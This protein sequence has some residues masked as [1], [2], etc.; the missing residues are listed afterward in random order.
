MAYDLGT[1]VNAQNEAGSDAN[2]NPGVAIFNVPGTSA[3]AAASISVNITD[4]AQVA[5]AASGA[6]SSD[7]TNLLA[8]ANLQNQTIIGGDTPS[9]YYSSFVT[10]VGSLVSGVSTQNTAQ[11]ASVS[12]L[13]NQVNSLSSVNLN[14]EAS[15]LETFEQSYQS[16]SKIFTILDEVM[17]AALNLG[18]E[19]TYTT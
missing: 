17:T 13:Q 8:M 10:T 5:A 18:V 11:E 6:G 9:N 19:T 4:P 1:A 3:G 16:A 2:G 14:E 12:Q 15:S 7:D